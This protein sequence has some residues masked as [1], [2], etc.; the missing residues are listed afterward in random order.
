MQA[1]LALAGTTGDAEAFAAAR[2]FV[3]RSLSPIS[4]HR[5]SAE[6]RAAIAQSLLE[7]F[8]TG[9]VA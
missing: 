1:E 3:A 5:G 6:Y 8:R 2:R 4:D 7:K 9:I